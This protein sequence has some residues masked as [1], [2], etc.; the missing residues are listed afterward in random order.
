[1][2]VLKEVLVSF[3]SPPESQI[4]VLFMKANSSFVINSTSRGCLLQEITQTLEIFTPWTIALEAPQHKGPP[5]TAS[6]LGPVWFHFN[7]IWK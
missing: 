3:S 1:M 2:S 6:I 7:S 4:V 5:H